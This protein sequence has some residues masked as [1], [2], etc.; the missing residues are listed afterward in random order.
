MIE[1]LSRYLAESDGAAVE[2]LESV[3]PRLRRLFEEVEFERFAALV[4]S[5][6][7]AEALDHLRTASDIHIERAR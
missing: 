6:S 1:Q 7:F 4:E 5:Y 2:Y 3:A